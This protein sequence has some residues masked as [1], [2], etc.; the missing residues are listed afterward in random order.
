[1]TVLVLIEISWRTA[2]AASDVYVG[3]ST[4]KYLVMFKHWSNCIYCSRSFIY[5]Y[6]STE[7]PT[8]T[9][10]LV[11][12]SDFE[13]CIDYIYFLNA[14]KYLLFTHQNTIQ[15]LLKKF[16]FNKKN[17]ISYKHSRIASVKVCM[18]FYLVLKDLNN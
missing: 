11:P 3:I 8:D 13:M 15:L 10:T 2:T 9:V 12:T 18:M 6:F 14:A 4:I 7:A 5:I 16:F 1:M 17:Q